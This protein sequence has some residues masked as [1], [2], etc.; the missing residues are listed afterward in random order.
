QECCAS[1]LTPAAVAVLYDIL[2]EVVA[3]YQIPLENIYNMD[4]KGIQMGVGEWTAVL[5]YLLYPC[6]LRCFGLPPKAS[7]Q[8]LDLVT[9]LEAVCMDG[10]ALHPAVIFK[11]IHFLLSI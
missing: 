5:V 9:I 3:Q 11:R 6:K 10:S 8:Q 2:K 4:K 1:S 7:A